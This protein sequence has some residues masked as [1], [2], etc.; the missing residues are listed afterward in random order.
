MPIATAITSTTSITRQLASIESIALKGGHHRQRNGRVPGPRRVAD[1]SRAGSPGRVAR[2]YARR[3]ASGLPESPPPRAG[4]TIG[5]AGAPARARSRAT[6][7][8][9]F[10]AA[11][12]S[13]HA[14]LVVDRR[15]LA[16]SGRHPAT[17]RRRRR[18][19]EG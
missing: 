4:S 15:R 18:L 10:G 16:L 11:A 19:L 12:R 7:L 13:G 14:A 1:Q 3:T 5:L 17:R 6:G 9:G 8:A 2:E